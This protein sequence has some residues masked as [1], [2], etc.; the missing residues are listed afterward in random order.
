MG[1]WV[2]LYVPPR[3]T[4]QVASRVADGNNSSVSSVS[5]TGSDQYCVQ[6]AELGVAGCCLPPFDHCTVAT[7]C[8]NRDAVSAF[9][10]ASCS[11][12]TDVELW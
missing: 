8:V 3:V 5:C 11:T 6:K 9:C 2:L 12:V 10:G 7:S 4:N 1:G